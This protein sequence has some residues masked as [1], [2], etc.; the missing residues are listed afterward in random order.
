MERHEIEQRLEELRKE[1]RR[2]EAEFNYLNGK[3]TGKMDMLSELLIATPE[4][5][6]TDVLAS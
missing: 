3:I 5:P 1:Q 2:L 6:A 4:L